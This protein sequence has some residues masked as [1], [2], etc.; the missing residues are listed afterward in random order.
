MRKYK[1]GYRI[2]MNKIKLE[3]LEVKIELTK[4]CFLQCKHCSAR[5]S[6]WL[7][8]EIKSEFIDR[9]LSDSKMIGK[10]VLTGGEPLVCSH[11]FK[12][13]EKLNNAGLKPVI[14]TSGFFK[15]NHSK[16]IIQSLYGKVSQ[17]IVSLHGLEFVHDRITQTDGSFNLTI[18]FMKD[19]REYGIPI[20]IHIVA[21]RENIKTIPFLIHW[22]K[23]QGFL[24]FSILRYVPQ[25]RGSDKNIGPPSI[26]ELSLLYYKL[27]KNGIRFGAP[28]NFIRRNKILCK[29]GYRTVSV[30]AWGNVIP[31]DSFKDIFSY[32]IECN[33]G[34]NNLNNIIKNSNYFIFVRENSRMLCEDECCLGQFLLKQKKDYFQVISYG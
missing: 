13:L 1:R 11:F 17:L 26:D 27:S 23:N 6:S 8:K 15:K 24:N 19:V 20:D 32:N 33:L 28:F 9:I 7:D 4:K 25:G 5:A 3:N 16:T 2:K 12:T 18:Q 14:Y 21:L 34:Y 22:L 30:D 29:A 10:I 31:C